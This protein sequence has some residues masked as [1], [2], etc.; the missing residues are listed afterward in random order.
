MFS[1]SSIGSNYN[2]EQAIMFASEI[3]PDGAA[4]LEAVNSDNSNP[5][6][7]VGANANN[8]RAQQPPAD[9]YDEDA[10]LAAARMLH[11]YLLLK[12]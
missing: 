1:A 4:A 7:N 5:S 10:A 2:L 12:K 8:Q 9:V 6:N 3:G 11:L